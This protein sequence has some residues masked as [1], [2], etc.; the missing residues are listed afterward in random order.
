MPL[1]SKFKM[2]PEPKLVLAV[3]SKLKLAKNKLFAEN[4]YLP[5]TCIASAN[6]G[7]LPIPL[8]IP[9]TSTPLELNFF[10]PIKLLSEIIIEPS[11]NKINALPFTESMNPEM[12]KF[13]L[14]L[15]IVNY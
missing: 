9:E 15:N 5:L 6:V 2:P 11:S 13:L 1:I 7:E 10:M 12:P 3:P 4:T 8:K 14:I